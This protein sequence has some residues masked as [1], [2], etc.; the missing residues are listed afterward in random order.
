MVELLWRLEDLAE[1]LQGLVYSTEQRTVTNSWSRIVTS[2][3]ATRSARAVCKPR[4]VLASCKIR[5]L[6][7]KSSYEYML[8]VR[9]LRHGVFCVSRLH[10]I[11]FAA[12]DQGAFCCVD[13]SSVIMR[14]SVN[15]VYHRWVT[16]NSPRKWH[17]STTSGSK[18]SP[19]KIL[20]RNS[21][22]A[23]TPTWNSAWT[24]KMKTS[25]RNRVAERTSLS[26]AKAMPTT[27]DRGTGDW[28]PEA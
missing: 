10:N 16:N 28:R 21:S 15:N 9:Q 3:W 8:G 25:T 18:S 22:G 27:R 1:D 23:R 2:F 6:I 24:T 7:N 11:D 14:Q 12:H 5:C 26:T 13:L 19:R 4:V 20:H 17:T